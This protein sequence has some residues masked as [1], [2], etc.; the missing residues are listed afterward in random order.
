MFG[1][2]MDDDKQ[3]ANMEEERLVSKQ[4]CVRQIEERRLQIDL[5]DR[6]KRW[7]R[8]FAIDISLM[9]VLVD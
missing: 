2:I 8:G 9:G 7:G 3:H 1:L 6:K 4:S 5:L